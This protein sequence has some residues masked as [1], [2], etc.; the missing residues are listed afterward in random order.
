MLNFSNGFRSLIFAGALTVT[1]IGCSGVRVRA[2]YRVYDPYYSD[3]HVWGPPEV[4]YYNNWIVET[5]RPY[6][7]YR[8]LR[9][10]ER[11][12]YWRWRHNGRH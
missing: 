2:G 3:Y 6:R 12:D 1:L 9:P 8:R 5:H 11:R 7:D 4:G 10:A